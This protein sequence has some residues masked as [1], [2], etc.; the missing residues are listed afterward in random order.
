MWRQLPKA[1]A[2]LFSLLYVWL[3]FSIIESKNESVFY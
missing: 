2:V 1:K 3:S